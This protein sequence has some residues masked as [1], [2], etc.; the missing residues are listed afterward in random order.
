MFRELN[1]PY[2]Y[3]MNNKFNKRFRKFSSHFDNFVTLELKV[4]KYFVTITMMNY[5]VNEKKKS[6]QMKEVFLSYQFLRNIFILVITV[7]YLRN[8]DEK[9]KRI[10]FPIQLIKI[11]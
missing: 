5:L 2:V 8:V 7:S 4:R 1:E 11:S 10:I 6:N 9:I 3:L